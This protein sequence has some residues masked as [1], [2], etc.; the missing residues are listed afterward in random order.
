MNTDKKIIYRKIGDIRLLPDNPRT[1]TPEDMERLK[2]SIRK[3]PDYLEAHPPVLSDR[4]GELVVIDGNQR[5]KACLEMGWEEIP[6]VLLHGLTE[7][8]EREITIRANVNNGKWD[9]DKLL[10]GYD[11]T[12]L[13][14]WG[15]EGMFDDQPGETEDAGKYTRKIDPPVYSPK[16]AVPPSV[17]SLYDTE[18]YGKLCRDIDGSD[19]DNE[20]KEFLKMAATRHIVFDYARIAEYYAHA[21]AKVQRLMEDSALV[22]IDFNKAVADGY[23]KLKDEIMDIMGEDYEE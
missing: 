13:E 9:I 15:V 10:A 21:E 19:V 12:D 18:R 20:V 2:D 4:T 3:S 14:S 6:T 22:I 23:T 1:I 7:E 5:V 17:G 8:R 16:E 11:V